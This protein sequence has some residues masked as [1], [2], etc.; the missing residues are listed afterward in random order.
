MFVTNQFYPPLLHRQE[1]LIAS[2]AKLAWLPITKDSKSVAIAMRLATG[3][4]AKIKFGAIIRFA[5]G[6]QH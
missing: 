1:S 4:Q 6:L 3:E 5:V 2:A